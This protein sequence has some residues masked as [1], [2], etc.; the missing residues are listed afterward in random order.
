MSQFTA[1]KFVQPVKDQG[2]KLHMD[3]HGA[4]KDNVIVE[5]LWKLLKYER[6][7][8]YAYDS[9]TEARKSIMQYMD[10]YNTSRPHT[11]LGKK[12]TG[13]GLYNIAAGS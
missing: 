1:G 8:L 10:W 7:Y 11:S 5:R 9:V 4:W 2:C 6:V 3:G 12:N 13:R